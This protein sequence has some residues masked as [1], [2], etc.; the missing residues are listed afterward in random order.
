MS[1]VDGTKVCWWLECFAGLNIT[2]K[3]TTVIIL[4]TLDR[5]CPW[6]DPPDCKMLE[7]DPN[8]TSQH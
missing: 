5:F 7:L 2:R 6:G 4:I 1:Q 3:I 8:Y